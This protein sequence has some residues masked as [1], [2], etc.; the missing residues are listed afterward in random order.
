[1]TKIHVRIYYKLSVIVCLYC[2]FMMRVLFHAAAFVSKTF[3]SMRKYLNKAL[4]T[5]NDRIYYICI[6]VCCR[7]TEQATNGL[8]VLK[9]LEHCVQGVI[10][11][12]APKT[13]ASIGGG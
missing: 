13:S 11:S 2:Y 10:L 12:N 9:R 6:I 1:M 8:D 7:V 5:N 3:I 4:D